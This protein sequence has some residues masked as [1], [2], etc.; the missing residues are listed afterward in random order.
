MWIDIRYAVRMLRKTPAFTAVA[1]I[2]LALGIGANTAIFTVVNKLLLRPLPYADPSR[3]A[4]LFADRRG[5][6]QGYSYLRYNLLSQRS[7]AF[8]GVAAFAS[9]TFNL[10]GRGDPGT[11]FG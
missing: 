8:S 1:V 7:H 2:T 9:D 5:E 3:L 6:L 4:L 10:T 11:A